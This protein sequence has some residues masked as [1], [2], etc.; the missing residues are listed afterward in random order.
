MTRTFLK[1]VNTLAVA[2]VIADAVWIVLVRFGVG[3]PRPAWTLPATGAAVAVLL[4]LIPFN[5]SELKRRKA[6]RRNAQVPPAS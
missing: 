5:L 6:A 4:L 1:A 3:P 2:W